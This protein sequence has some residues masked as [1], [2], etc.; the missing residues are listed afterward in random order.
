MKY[1]KTL[2]LA[3]ALSLTF[4]A[5]THAQSTEEDPLADFADLEAALD[6]LGSLETEASDS[7]SLS[8]EADAEASTEATTETESEVN[9][10]ANL[11]TKEEASGKT[12]NSRLLPKEVPEGKED[13]LLYNIPGAIEYRGM[14]FLRIDSPRFFDRFQKCDTTED[15]KTYNALARLKI[16]QGSPLECRESMEYQFLPYKTFRTKH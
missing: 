2:A 9:T 16:S 13:Y 4:A 12:V 10:E 14:T 11:E 7:E 15:D 6:E 5:T 8:S 3:L 1:T